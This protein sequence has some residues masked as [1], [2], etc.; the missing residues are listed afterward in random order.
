MADRNPST[1]KQYHAAFRV[2]DNT[3]EVVSK[4]FSIMYFTV[5]AVSRISNIHCWPSTSTC[6]KEQEEN[7]NR[8]K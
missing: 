6:C 5:P 8:N 2:L 1:V 3:T 4:N 7:K